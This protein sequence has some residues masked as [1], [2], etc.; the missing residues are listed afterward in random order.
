M[1][2]SR[3]KR[4]RHSASPRINQPSRRSEKINIERD[5]PRL[6][7]GSATLVTDES[8]W[9]R[10]MQDFAQKYPTFEEMRQKPGTRWILLRFEPG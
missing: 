1:P 8:E 3:S 9:N 7:E 4:R 5:K 2:Q 6:F 10:A